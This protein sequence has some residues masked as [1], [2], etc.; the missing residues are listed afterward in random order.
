MNIY[1]HLFIFFGGGWWG[2]NDTMGILGGP[3]QTWTILGSY[4]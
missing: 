1:F 2:Y 3:S 4:F